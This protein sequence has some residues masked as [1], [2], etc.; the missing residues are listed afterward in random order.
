VS[1]LHAV[2]WHGRSESHNGIITEVPFRRRGEFKTQEKDPSFALSTL[3]GPMFALQPRLLANSGRGLKET[4]VCAPQ[5]RQAGQAVNNE[6]FQDMIDDDG[7]TTPIILRFSNLVALTSSRIN[8]S[9][10]FTFLTVYLI[11]SAV[12]SSGTPR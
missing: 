11:D 1:P 6:P 3:A 10:G 4:S 8:P 7:G 9:L 2:P 5:L 12:A